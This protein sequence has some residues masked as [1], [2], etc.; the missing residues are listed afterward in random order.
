[1]SGSLLP[2]YGTTIETF[3]QRRLN[4]LAMIQCEVTIG[5]SFFM[6]FKRSRSPVAFSTAVSLRLMENQ[7]KSRGERSQ[8]F[9]N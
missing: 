4:R 7:L 8:A 3:R 6:N 2:E 1:L 5:G 9:K